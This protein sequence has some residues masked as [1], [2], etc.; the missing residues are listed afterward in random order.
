MS[1]FFASGGQSF[2]FSIS[3]SNE[4]PGWV[5]SRIYW[6]DLFAVQGALR[7]LPQ[8]HNPKTSILLHVSSLW[9]NSHIH[10]KTISIETPVENHKT[11][12]ENHDFDYKDLFPASLY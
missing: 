3:P 1:Q 7:S 8:N 4:Y 11:S 12:L 5:S 10:R 9:P 6:F 2:S